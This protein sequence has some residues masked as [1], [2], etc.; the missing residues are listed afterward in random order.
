[1]SPP[2]SKSSRAPPL[3]AQLPVVGGRRPTPP[4]IR[5][6]RPTRRRWCWRPSSAASSC[7]SVAS[8]SVVVRVDGRDLEFDVLAINEFDSTRKR[9]SVL[10]RFPDHSIY[11]IVKGADSVVES[12]LATDSDEH[13]EDFEFDDIFEDI[14]KKPTRQLH[15]CRR[16]DARRR[17]RRLTTT[18]IR[19]TTRCRRRRDRAR[20]TTTPTTA[21]RRCGTR[22]PRR[23]RL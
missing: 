21:D 11:L 17:R 4:S 19:T 3:D 18:T 6:S 9:M 15:C 23:R 2:R 12:A 16:D 20:R 14:A 13:P 8:T 22:A 7:A 5:P 1:M 10:V